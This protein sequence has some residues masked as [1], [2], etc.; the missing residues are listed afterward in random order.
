M[1]NIV[2]YL[3]FNYLVLMFSLSLSAQN[4]GLKDTIY[5]VFDAKEPPAILDFIASNPSGQDSVLADNALSDFISQSQ[6][7][8]LLEKNISNIHTAN[9]PHTVQTVY[10]VYAQTGQLKHLLSFQEKYPHFRDSIRLKKDIEIAKLHGQLPEIYNE[11]N[12]QNY[13]NYIK[14]AAPKYTA[15]LALQNMIKPYLIKEDWPT[16]LKIIKSYQSYFDNKTSVLERMIET[17]ASPIDNSIEKLPMNNTLNSED[18]EYCPVLTT[19]GKKLFFCR[20]KGFKERIYVSEFMGEKWDTAQLIKSFAK[21]ANKA[22][23][24]VTANGANLLVF[25]NGRIKISELEDG[26]WSKLQNFSKLINASKWQGGGS[27]SSDGQVMIFAAIRGDMV[28]VIDEGNIDLFVAFKDRKGEWGNIKNLSNQLNTSFEERTPFLHPDMKS[29]YFSSNGLGG[30]GGFDVYKTTRLDDTWTNWSAPLHL[31]KSINTAGDDW[32][33]IISTDGQTAYFAA[34]GNNDEQDLF[35]VNIP[36]NYQPQEVTTITGQLTNT[37][38]EP[39]LATIIIE[40]L[41]SNSTI[42]TT[43]SDSKNGQYF[44][45]L[46]EERL[47]AYTIEKEGFFPASGHLDLR[48]STTI[49]SVE[50]NIQ[51]VALKEMIEQKMALP[52]ENLFFESNKANI[53]A[54]SFP[55]LNRLAQLLKDNAFSLQL[56]GYTD[57]VGSK[58]YNKE[59]SK[60]RAAAVKKYLV[61]QGCSEDKI[62]AR[63]NGMENSIADNATEEG[64]AKDRRV[65]IR[66]EQSQQ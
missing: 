35:Q 8:W 16:A 40:D 17:I 20:R 18:S 14:K 26:N 64:R 39:V 15:F 30:L 36:K 19:D 28:G 24:T 49:Q 34:D 11:A 50:K 63:G 43:K 56:D 45:V 1:K 54:T 46:A 60:N 32:G 61:S 13:D 41:A 65:E 58:D 55:A 52:I 5:A 48:E 12:H 57:N 38:G 37:K 42:T 66:L 22:P 62:I 31:G 10:D 6:E 23:L 9:I 7:I 21:G 44:V 59:L 4:T 47:Y 53:Q 3:V 51:L 27:I 33:Y 29:L 25:E 2:K